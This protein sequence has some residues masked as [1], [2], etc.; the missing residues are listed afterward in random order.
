M[1][2]LHGLNA[3]QKAAVSAESGPILVLAGPGSGKTR[4][5][6]QRIVYLIQTLRIPPWH[7]LA[8]TFTNKAAREM[9]ERVERLV[10][11]ELRGLLMGTFHAVCARL[12]RRETQHLAGYTPEF[13]IFDEDDQKQVIKQVLAD[14]NLDEKRFPPGKMLA[15]IGMAKNELITA[16]AYQANNYISEVTRRAYTRYQEL[17]RANNAMDFDDL[18]MNIV[19]LFD[20]QPDVLRKYQEQFR[21]ILVDEFQDTNTAQYGLLTRLAALYQN[22]FVVGDADQSIY[23]WRGADF[24]NIQRFRRQYPQA[25]VILLEQ[26]YRSTQIVLDAAQAVI[27]HNRDRVDKG[28]FTERRGGQKIVV[29]ELYNEVEEAQQVVDTI[30]ELVLGGHNPGDFAVMYRTN[31]QSRAIE[32]AFLRAGLPYRLVGATRFYGRRE[33]KDVIAYLRL[34]HNPRDEVS[35]N[36]VVNTPPRGIGQKT[37]EQLGEWG[38]A[39][40]WGSAESLLHLITQPDIPHPFTGRALSALTRVGHLLQGWLSLRV[41]TPVGDLMGQ[42]L[43]QIGFHD[44]LDDGTEEGRDRWANILELRGVTQAE[45]G[46]SL[47]EFLEEVALVSDVD[48]LAEGVKAPTLLTLHAAKGLEFRVVF[49]TGL[50]EGL[51]PHSRSLGNPDDI[52]EERRLFYVGLTRAMERLYLTHAFRRNLYGLSDVAGPSR[53]LSEIPDQFLAGQVVGRQQAR[54]Q[55]SSWDWSPSPAR[56][57]ARPKSTPP[58]Q[59][60]RGQDFGRISSPTPPPAEEPPAPPPARRY[61]T[62]Q[63]VRHAKFGPGIVIEAK[64]TGNDEEVTVAFKENG[65]KRLAASFAHLEIVESG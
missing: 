46:V 64:I 60:S 1:D 28:L 30:A 13:V 21:H 51:L 52:A 14:L 53:F 33:V 57:P 31:A 32:E 4:V 16:E 6:T 37:R 23:K 61:H 22:I 7:I 54:Q 49:I 59:V 20:A 18:L 65:I 12:L 63:S 44:Y 9:R 45:P 25:Q 38:Q 15:G 2:A 24:R 62:G 36:R 47:S 41:H 39:Q 40:G 17:L 42:I 55:V 8:V 29:R 11:G 50:E 3:Q 10:E 34:V 43:E 5:L 26:N 35:F 56:E 48:S 58:T 19:H 27:R